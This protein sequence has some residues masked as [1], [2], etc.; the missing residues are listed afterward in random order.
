M[1]KKEY[2]EATNSWSFIEGL[3]RRYTFD[4]DF[5]NVMRYGEANDLT[6]KDWEVNLLQIYNE[7][8]LE[9]LMNTKIREI[10]SM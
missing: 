9:D 3:I 7:I 5:Y 2:E 10:L 6:Q 1:N 4:V 8:E